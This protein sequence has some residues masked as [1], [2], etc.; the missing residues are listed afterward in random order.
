MTEST[1]STETET[2]TEQPDSSASPDAE[3][4]TPEADD[5]RIAE[6]RREAA[7]RRTKLRAAEAERDELTK[8][9]TSMRRAEV[10]R[11]AGDQLA[12]PNDLWR[13][14]IQLEALL[15]EDGSLDSEKVEA[16]IGQLVSEKPHYRKAAPSFDGGA[17]TS[18]ETAPDFAETLRKAAG[19]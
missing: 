11:L 5:P 19:G 6:L 17:R 1:E 18:V 15:A 10:E 12:D 9:V 2:E 14:E 8:Q 7:S 3:L 16:A 13:S 4:S